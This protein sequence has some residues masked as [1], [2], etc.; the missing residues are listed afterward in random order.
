MNTLKKMFLVI[1]ITSAIIVS[2][3]HTVT[4][5]SGQH[6]WYDL[7]A[8]GS[9]VPCKKCHAEIWAE[10]ATTGAH[11]RVECDGCHRTD[12]SVGYASD[13]Q[14][15]IVPGQGGHSAST[16]EC[17]ICHTREAET[18][19]THDYLKHGCTDCHPTSGDLPFVAPAAGGFGLTGD[20]G[21]TGEKAAH[22]LFVQ[23]SLEDPLMEG[24]NEA[25]VQCH[26]E[27]SVDVSYYLPQGY[28]IVL[29]RECEWDVNISCSNFTYVEGSW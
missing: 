16:E 28:E 7:S 22:L 15:N 9:D 8:Q 14:G 25:C 6:S 4:L 5:F 24:A 1:A 13:Q 11:A 21:D 12:A 17:M 27:T 2:S 23:E 20:T 18:N 29:N 26:T 3:L 19:F 10:M